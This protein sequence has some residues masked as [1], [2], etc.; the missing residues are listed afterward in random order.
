LF[1]CSL[2]TLIESISA[3]RFVPDQLD[4]GKTA[5][6]L[7]SDI[8]VIELERD[9]RNNSMRESGRRQSAQHYG[10]VKVDPI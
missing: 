1:I 9:G 7:Q 4:F 5:K 10:F 2:L 3:A 6:L 8:T